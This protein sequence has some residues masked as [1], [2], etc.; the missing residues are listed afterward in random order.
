MLRMRGRPKVIL[1][2]NYEEALQFY[3]RY[4]NNLLGIISDISY[5]RD[6]ELDNLA[7]VKLC[8][9]VKMADQYLPFLLQSSEIANS[10]YAKELNV[11]FLHKGSN[12]LDIELREYVNEYLAFGKFIFLDPKS[13]K[14]IAQMV[15]C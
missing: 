2:T 6:N 1:A 15:E 11:K 8:K 3:E 9:K 13:M 10:K 12:T 14:E 7:G 4:K 5:K